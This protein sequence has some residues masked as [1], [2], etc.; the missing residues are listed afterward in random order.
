MAFF[1][2]NKNKIPE[3]LQGPLSNASSQN[4]TDSEY[5]IQQLKTNDTGTPKN[6]SGPDDYGNF[7]NSSNATKLYISYVPNNGKEKYTLMFPAIIDAYTEDFKA[8]FDQEQLYGR[9]DPVQ[10]Y[11][12]TSRTINVSFK[13][14][15]Y[16]E[17]HAL[18]NLQALSTLSQFLYPVYVQDGSESIS[19]ATSISQSPLWRVK[20]ANL[21]QSTKINKNLSN[22]DYVDSG[23]LVA[24]TSF[25]FQPDLEMGFF[26][27][28]KTFLFPKQIKLSL[29]L[30]AV[31]EST[32][33][34]VSNNK[35]DFNFISNINEKNGKI[36]FGTKIFPWG[37]I[38]FLEGQV[39]SGDEASEE[40]FALE[41]INGQRIVEQQIQEEG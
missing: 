18:R 35:V 20:F 2:G 33:G 22:N 7:Y 6:G 41:D 14:L 13:V 10:K 9:M 4:F 19:N 25:T 21:I 27:S 11:K 29:G 15:A 38:T 3:K 34:W 39:K 1:T 26:V 37:D 24:P 12:N 32:L 23:L 5:Y 17:N 16:D 30:T 36:D 28:Q 8:T 40:E 31:H